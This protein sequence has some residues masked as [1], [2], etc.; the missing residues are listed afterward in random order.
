MNLKKYDGKC[1]RIFDSEDNYFD[2]FCTFNSYEFNECEYG[3]E[4]DSL[5]ILNIKFYKSNIKKIN[6]LNNLSDNQYSNLEELIID[7]GIDFIEDALD[8]ENK[9]H[10]NRLLLC[11]KDNINKLE[12]KETIN[13][14]LKRYCIK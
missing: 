14:I 6:T 12:D 1:V 3:R 5:D 4:E 9:I 8:Y 2:G 7:G 10:I 11:I 13:K